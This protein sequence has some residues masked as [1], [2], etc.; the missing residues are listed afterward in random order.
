MHELVEIHTQNRHWSRAADVL[1]RLVA[2]TTGREKVCYLVA[3]ASI[4]NSEL[5]APGEAVALYDRALDEDP[6]DRRTFERIEHI[7]IERQAVA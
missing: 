1:E 2:L 5:D 3:L 7:L 4:L 6:R